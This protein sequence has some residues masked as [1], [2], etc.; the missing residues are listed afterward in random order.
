MAAY[1]ALAK[2][3]KIVVKINITLLLFNL[4]TYRNC[5]EFQWNH[6]QM[7]NNLQYQPLSTIFWV[8]GHWQFQFLWELGLN[9]QQLT[10]TFLWPKNIKINIFIVILRL[11]YKIILCMV[12]YEV[13]QF[14][15]PSNLVEL[16]PQIIWLK[17]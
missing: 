1:V 9:A 13:F 2:K 7:Y 10:H 16:E 15:F 11:R 3:K 14:C 17:W 12:Q 8:L 5:Q 4:T 6:E